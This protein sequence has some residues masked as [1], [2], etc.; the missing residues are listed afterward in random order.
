MTLI[1]KILQVYALLLFVNF[2]FSLSTL[3]QNKW[4]VLLEKICRPAVNFGT[5]I[6]DRLFKNR[7]FGFDIGPL[8]GLLLVLCIVLVI[9]IIV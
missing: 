9:K 8:A 2:L 4:T 1:L 7:R 5:S 3:N 6:A